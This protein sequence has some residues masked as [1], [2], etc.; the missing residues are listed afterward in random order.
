MRSTAR[1]FSL[2]TLNPNLL[3][4]RLTQGLHAKRNIRISISVQYASEFKALETQEPN[5]PATTL[6]AFVPG[7]SRLLARWIRPRLG[8]E[9]VCKV[10]LWLHV[11]FRCGRCWKTMSSCA[12]PR[13]WRG[14]GRACCHP[15]PRLGFAHLESRLEPSIDSML[16]QAK[17]MGCI[18][19]AFDVRP[20][21]R[22]QVV[23]AG[24][25]QLVGI[26]P[27]RPPH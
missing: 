12:G 18:V 27:D 11:D 21:T 3:G 22:E 2:W 1:G 8:T 13:D 26:S 5:R 23:A 17:N 9:R 15:A 19:R 14:R 20:A 10:W 24:G 25:R 7:S 16:R 4:S 6:A